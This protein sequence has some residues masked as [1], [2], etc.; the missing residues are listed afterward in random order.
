VDKTNKL[1]KVPSPDLFVTLSKEEQE[2][3]LKLDSIKEFKKGTVLLKEGQMPIVSYFVV[4]GLVRKYKINENGDE[5]TLE[6]YSEQESVISSFDPSKPQPSKFNLECLEDC[7]IS[8][9]SYEEEQEMYRRF[10]RF[11]RMCRETIISHGLPSRD[12][13]TSLLTDL[14]F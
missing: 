4:N 12:I 10:P 2:A 9:V 8:V 5:L 6:F 14:I 7:K 11:E 13:Q 1:D 3:V